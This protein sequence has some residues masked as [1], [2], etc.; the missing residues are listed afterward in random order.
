MSASVAKHKRMKLPARE[1]GLSFHQAIQRMKRERMCQSETISKEKRLTLP[2]ISSEKPIRRNLSSDEQSVSFQ[3]VVRRMKSERQLSADFNSSKG[4]D[5]ETKLKNDD[6]VHVSGKSQCDDVETDR[7]MERTSIDPRRARSLPWFEDSRTSYQHHADYLKRL[8]TLRDELINQEHENLSNALERLKQRQNG[9]ENRTTTR[10]RDTDGFGFEVQ[11]RKS[12]MTTVEQFKRTRPRRSPPRIM[13]LEGKQIMEPQAF[14]KSP[15]SPLLASSS[16]PVRTPDD[17]FKLNLQRLIQP[18][19]SIPNIGRKSTTSNKQLVLETSPLQKKSTPPKLS[20]YPVLERPGPLYKGTLKTG[21]RLKGLIKPD[22]D[23]DDD[24][25]PPPGFHHSDT[26]DQDK[27]S[28][29]Q[30]KDYYC[31]YYLPTNTPVVP[32]EDDMSFYGESVHSSRKSEGRDSRKRVNAV[33]GRSI[34]K[35]LDKSRH[36]TNPRRTPRRDR[37]YYSESHN[38]DSEYSGDSPPPSNKK[39]IVVDMPAIVF[40][41]ATP[42]RTRIDFESDLTPLRKTYKQNE[43]RQRELKNLIEDVKELNLRNDT[44]TGFLQKAPDE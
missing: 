18:T 30:L 17:S 36:R 37:K 40:N 28:L 31:I 27:M 14:Y 29:E 12:L 34:L 13:P 44:L 4:G 11:P 19:S 16:L 20:P 43:L 42:E 6:A 24:E 21:G 15:R 35:R 39:Q 5:T 33:E 38:Y 10:P 3:E 8:S 1:A 23:K 32:N 41:T 25:I 26:M 2:R 9:K 22:D 7:L